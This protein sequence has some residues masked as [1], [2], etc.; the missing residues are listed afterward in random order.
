[1][2]LKRRRMRKTEARIKRN[3]AR[4]G[5]VA[6]D[7]VD[8]PEIIRH[9]HPYLAPDHI[10]EA[11]LTVGSALNEVVSNAC[12]VIAIGPFGC[13]PNRIAEAILIE[14]MTAADK[15][16]A[17]AN[18]YHL[19]KTLKGM[20]SLPFLAVESDGSPFPQN[21][22]SKLEAFCLRARRLHARMVAEAS[23]VNTT[24]SWRA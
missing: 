9:A 2:A 18:P 19:R 21:I 16:R 3:L 14:V 23:P 12:G 8:I 11:I 5:L 20:A 22:E 10:G 4:S 13:M 6:E 7:L 24:R 15:L 1:M 17:E